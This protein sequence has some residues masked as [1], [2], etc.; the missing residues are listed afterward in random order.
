MAA[1]KQREFE[2]AAISD[3]SS[4]PFIVEATGRLGKT[5][6]DLLHDGF[7]E[8][9]VEYQVN[10]FVRRMSVSIAK[11]NGGVHFDGAE[12]T[13]LSPCHRACI[14]YFSSM[15]LDHLWVYGPLDLVSLFSH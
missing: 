6:M 10:T 15:I 2:D 3:V 12:V 4:V 5:A 9:Y 7:G 13:H 1:R 14:I 11:M 8:Q